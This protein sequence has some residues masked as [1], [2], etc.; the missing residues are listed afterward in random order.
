MQH[1]GRHLGHAREARGVEQ[2]LLGEAQGFPGRFAFADVHGDTD[3]S[4]HRA[5]AIAHRADRE[6]DGKARAILAKIGPFARLRFAALRGGDEDLEARGQSE[7]RGARPDFRGI[8]EDLGRAPAD[9]LLRVVPE[10]PLGPEIEDGDE[11]LG[12]RA[13]D[14]VL[15]R[16]A[17]H[18]GEECGG[19][20]LLALDA[21]KV[22]A[23]TGLALAEFAEQGAIL[24]ELGAHAAADRAQPED[25]RHAHQRTLE[26]G[27][28]FAEELVGAF[29]EKIPGLLQIHPQRVE[30]GHP[31]AQVAGDGLLW[32]ALEH[33]GDD[34]VAHFEI[35]PPVPRDFCGGRGALPL[36]GELLIFREAL[37]DLRLRGARLVAVIDLQIAVRGA[38][39]VE[40]RAPGF[41]RL[42]LQL[43]DEIE[44]ADRAG[45]AAPR[46]LLGAVEVREEEQP[47]APGDEGDGDHRASEPI[48]VREFHRLTRRSGS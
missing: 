39:R 35:C 43:P 26:G 16:G 22:I 4:G 10:H 13:D 14:G 34:L 24:G 42:V 11:A 48:E 25:A 21:G 8:V 19:R 32:V 30:R 47:D 44:P 17:E 28:D 37:R 46:I 36:E 20:A 9:H 1:A 7:F 6:G 2:L 40:Q 5:R 12:G 29:L 38:Q 15:S 45:I 33:R 41:L 3:E 18:G 31:L 23:Q 27:I